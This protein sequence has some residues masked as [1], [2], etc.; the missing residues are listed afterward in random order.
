MGTS[1]QSCIVACG[2][3]GASHESGDE[4]LQSGKSWNRRALAPTVEEYEQALSLLAGLHPG[5]TI[6]GP[7]M[8]VATRI[9]DAVMADRAHHEQEIRRKERALESMREHAWR[10]S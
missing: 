4:Y 10:R 5:M 8:E 6:D 1:G 2:N 3:C 9:F 7:P